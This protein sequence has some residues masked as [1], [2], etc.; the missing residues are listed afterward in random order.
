M[1]VTCRALEL[2]A[3]DGD[4][5]ASA[6]TCSAGFYVRSLAHDLGRALGTGACLEAL[7]RTRSG[8]FGLE[9]AMPLELSWTVDCRPRAREGSSDAPLELLIPMDELL[10]G[11]PPSP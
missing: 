2:L 6:L 8:E 5:P 11:F 10:P 3:F 4:R 1:P 7:Q 9:E